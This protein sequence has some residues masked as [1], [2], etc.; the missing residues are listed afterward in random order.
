MHRRLIL[1]LLLA[2][3]L[4]G[5]PAETLGQVVSRADSAAVLLDAARSFEADG[6]WEVAEALFHR[7]T[8]QF[9][10]TEA[11]REAR[12]LLERP[13][14]EG[15]S[16]SSQAEL[17]VWSTTYG[18]WLGVAIPGALGADDP[19]PYG[20]GLLLGGP[21]GF[22]GGRALSRSM[23][24]SEGQVRAIT[25]GSL[26][27][28]WQGWGLLELMDWGEEEYCDWDVCWS[29]GP[30]GDDVLK[31]MVLGGLAG[32][33]TGAFL[34][35]K[36]IPSGVATTVNYGA[37]WGTWFGFA[38]GVV[39]D[40]EE[41]DLLA[42]ALLGGNAGLLYTAFRASDWN[43]SRP[44]AR[45]ISISGVIGLL[46]GFGLDL[47]MQPEED[48]VAMGIPLLT[49]AG[50]LALGAVMTSDSRAGEGGMGRG[51]REAGGDGDPGTSLLQLRDG[52]FSLGTPA[53]FPT[54]LPVDGPRRFSYRPALGFNLFS[55]RF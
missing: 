45:L 23:N 4:L 11:G 41:D 50:G 28:T 35:Q 54:L 51:R 20:V 22:L 13:T 53:P 48:K 30:D 29:D 12:A 38:G 5:R 8:E 33:G 47:L 21:G 32:I 31:A 42:S 6:R 34:A 55:S 44:R 17:M 36:P 43:L 15:T 24:L 7:L 26:W 49:S 16:R 14:P 46:G 27:G 9:G 18:A 3:V 10:D 1:P 25:F 19:A 40:L 37:L 2:C 39:A 52:K